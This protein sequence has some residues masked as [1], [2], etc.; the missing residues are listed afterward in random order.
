VQPGEVAAVLLLL[1]RCEV[2]GRNE[3]E[4][5]GVEWSGRAWL[6]SLFLLG[7]GKKWEGGDREINGC[8]NLEGVEEQ[9]L[10]L[11]R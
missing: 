3:L 4:W 1:K 2:S 10:C 5:S 8:T 9:P 7:R 11:N 6:A